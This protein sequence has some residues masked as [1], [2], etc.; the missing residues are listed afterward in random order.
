MSTDITRHGTATD[1]LFMRYVVPTLA[2][3]TIWFSPN[4]FFRT[5]AKSA[6][7]VLSA[8]FDAG[9]Y[10]EYPKAVYL[11]GD[12]PDTP[13]EE[14]RDAAKQKQLWTETLTFVNIAEGD[15]ALKNWA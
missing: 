13:S 15:T 11:N 14:S 9:E 10:G 2:P 5:P 6:A 7:D 8:A 12:T 1:R 4:G 3:L